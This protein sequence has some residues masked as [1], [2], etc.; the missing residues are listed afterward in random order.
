[1][2]NFAVNTQIFKDDVLSLHV[3]FSQPNTSSQ[4]YSSTTPAA[5]LQRQIKYRVTKQTLV[6]K[7][8]PDTHIILKV[9]IPMTT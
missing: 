5:L 7:A 2:L 8:C 1:M 4:T 9:L 6:L 3:P